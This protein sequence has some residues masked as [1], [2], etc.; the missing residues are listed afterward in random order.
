MDN[1]L[2]LLT[3]KTKIRHLMKIAKFGLFCLL[4]ALGTL[5]FSPVIHVPLPE[6]EAAG[7]KIFIQWAKSNPQDWEVKS[8]GDWGILPSKSEPVGDVALNGTA[9]GD[10]LLTGA[11]GWIFAINVQGVEFNWYDHYHVIQTG[12]TIVVTAWRDNPIL[13]PEGQK[14][15]DVV[16]FLEPA[17]DNKV[18]QINTRISTIIYAQPNNQWWSRGCAPQC[19]EN[20]TVL[21][22]DQFVAP[23]TNIYHG[24]YLSDAKWDEHLAARTSIHGWREWVN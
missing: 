7:I 5:I 14:Q 24:I 15:A 4:V 1:K 10:S 18:G 22:W 11:P 16:T 20:L 17:F 2:W 3:S 12:T 8:T 6:A 21:P 23:T 13:F 19:A 9:I